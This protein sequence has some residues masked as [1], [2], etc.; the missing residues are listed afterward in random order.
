[1]TPAFAD[2]YK[3]ILSLKKSNVYCYAN[4]PSYRPDRDYLTPLQESV[5]DICIKMDVT[6]PW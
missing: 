5:L 1:Y 2:L 4:S 3:I 6:L